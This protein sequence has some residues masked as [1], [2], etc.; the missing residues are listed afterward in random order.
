MKSHRQKTLTALGCHQSSLP[1]I[2]IQIS[3]F[4]ISEFF[5]DRVKFPAFREQLSTDR[6][7]L[8][9]HCT[10]VTACS[11]QVSSPHPG[12]EAVLPGLAVNQ[13]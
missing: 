4:L 3:E 2:W 1:V 8:E 10:R 13:L 6:C 7:E 11:L 9:F 5:L 12:N